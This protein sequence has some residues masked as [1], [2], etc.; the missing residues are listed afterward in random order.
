MIYSKPMYTSQ[1]SLAECVERCDCDDNNA[2]GG[3]PGG[4]QVV[5]QVV[6]QVMMIMALIMI[7]FQ[8]MVMAQ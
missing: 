8:M 1:Q 4:A 6:P 5:P 2:P 3:A 7:I